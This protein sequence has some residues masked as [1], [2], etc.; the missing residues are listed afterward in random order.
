M[1]R[2]RSRPP[3]WRRR[4]IVVVLPEGDDLVA[5]EA[6]GDRP[7]DRCAVVVKDARA[8]WRLLGDPSMGL[9]EAYVEGSLD[10]RPSIRAVLEAAI[11]L[12]QIE[13]HEMRKKAMAEQKTLAEEAAKEEQLL[14]EREAARKREQQMEVRLALTKQESEQK[15]AKKKAKEAELEG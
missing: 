5:A 7:G 14:F 12:K 11:A 15:R 3:L 13:R 8:A 6:A 10:L 9:A 4:E 2:R 1:P